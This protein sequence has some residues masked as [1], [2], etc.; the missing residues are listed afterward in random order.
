MKRPIKSAGPHVRLTTLLILGLK[1][2]LLRCRYD[3]RIVSQRLA[4]GAFKT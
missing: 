3:D 4:R 1:P 2:L